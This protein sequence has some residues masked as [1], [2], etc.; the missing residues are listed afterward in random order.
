MRL[1]NFFSINKVRSD[2][3]I[4]Y[5]STFLELI[6]GLIFMTTINN[7]LG[8]QSYGV[9]ITLISSFSLI[10]AFVSSNNHSGVSRFISIFN[11]KKE[12]TKLNN[13]IAIGIL[14]DLVTCIIFLIFVFSIKFFF[15]DFS[16]RFYF[17]TE[18]FYVL[19]FSI[20][21]KILAGTFKGILSGF[22]KFKIQSLVLIFALIIKMIFFLL[23]IK[24][25]IKSVAYSYLLFDII[26]FLGVFIFSIKYIDLKKADMK[27]GFK[28]HFNYMKL[29]F[30]SSSI[31][32]F[33]TK[34]DIL[35]LNY[36][37]SA[38]LV[39]QYETIKK[40]F[41]PLNHIGPSLSKI[42]FPKFA[43]YSI[44]RNLKKVRD[45]IK[46]ATKYVILAS[47]FYICFVFLVSNYYS[48]FQ[49][50]EIPK[51][52]LLI[53]GIYYF[54]ITTIWWGSIYF[55]NFDLKYTIKTN[56]I[57]LICTLFFYPFFL[58][59]TQN[60]LVGISIAILIAYLP[61]YIMG[62]SHLL[63]SKIK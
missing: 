4:D 31:K 46:K 10:T 8:V 17:E 57:L 42:L 6:I 60:K 61:P 28:E 3:S 18:I 15:V 22:E 35:L 47:I 48:F 52:M 34:A 58:L 30:T 62:V 1:I 41:L 26:F 49:K 32:A 37:T 45:I 14:I 9:L 23:V 24:N 44:D 36:F 25:G 5:I 56:L 59:I 63:K 27:S 7:K 29:N 55:Q 21:F 43:K 2:I 12:L 50:I 54:L 53:L 16:E 39:G 38:L 40:L 19:L 11:S 20:P 51:L 13:I 33:A